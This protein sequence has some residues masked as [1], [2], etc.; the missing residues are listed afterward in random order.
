MNTGSKTIVELSNLTKLYGSVIGINDVC[1]QLEPGAYGLLGP[2]GSGKTTLLNLM[3]GLLTP[4]IGDVQVFGHA[5]GHPET[6]ARIGFCP[7]F[8]G[9]YSN[10]SGFEWVT[11]LLEL[12]G[13]RHSEAQR[14]S[15]E[16]LIRVG[17]QDAMRRPIGSYSRGMRQRTKFAQAT[18][19]DPELVVL[20]EPFNGLDPIGRHDITEMLRQWVRNGRS[21]IISSHILHEVEAVTSSFLLIHGGRLLASGSAN[22]VYSLLSDVPSEITISCSDSR[23]LAV[24]LIKERLIDGAKMEADDSLTISTHHPLSVYQRLPLLAAEG[25]IIIRALRSSDDSLQ[26]VFNTLL[27]L[28]RGDRFS[29]ASQSTSQST[30][31]AQEFSHAR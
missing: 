8:E 24:R 10:V 21:L 12:Q 4:T 18:A 19:H 23:A 13:F 9:M 27:R 29:R 2:N 26:A 11:Y 20:D 15:E 1:L 30:T 31:P 28:R 22:E 3:T 17:M 25:P 5:P 6:L 7:G 14:R 16:A